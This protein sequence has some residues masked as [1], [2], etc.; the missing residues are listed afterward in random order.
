M[1]YCNPDC[2]GQKCDINLSFISH[3]LL[4]YICLYLFFLFAFA[5]HCPLFTSP[6]PGLSVPS[7][8]KLPS[9][10]Y[11]ICHI[12]CAGLFSRVRCYSRIQRH[13][14]IF[15]SNPDAWMRLVYA[16]L[17]HVVQYTVHVQGRIA[18]FAFWKWVN[19]KYWFLRPLLSSS[20]ANLTTRENVLKSRFA[21]NLTREIWHIHCTLQLHYVLTLHL[22][23]FLFEK[24]KTKF[25]WLSWSNDCD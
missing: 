19:D 14:Q 25:S 7:I 18:N 17:V 15:A 1:P 5:L 9:T 8:I 2:L 23:R 6:L 3:L 10:I 24:N 13:A 16:I 20:I 22:V 4:C 11:C 12:F 21:K